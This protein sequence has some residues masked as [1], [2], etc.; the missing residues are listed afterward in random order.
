MENFFDQFDQDKDVISVTTPDPSPPSGNFFDQFDEVQPQERTLLTDEE[1]Q[2]PNM[3]MAMIP[4][5]DRTPVV[6]PQDEV[7]AGG[8]R[9]D[10]FGPEVPPELLQ[11]EAERTWNFSDAG[12]GEGIPPT[13]QRALGGIYNAPREALE[14]PIAARDALSGS[15]DLKVIQEVLD[16]VWPKYK[17]GQ[18]AEGLVGDIIQEG[19]GFA[20]GAGALHKV[21]GA[22]LNALKGTRTGKAARAVAYEGAGVLGMDSETESMTE[23]LRILGM[24]SDGSYSEEV[25]LRKMNIL[26]EGLALAKGVEIGA[27]GIAKGSK[28]VNEY[29]IQPLKTLGDPEKL[30]DTVVRDAIMGTLRKV[31]INDT[32]NDIADDIKKIISAV[33]EGKETRISSGIEGVDDVVFKRDTMSALQEGM[34][35]IDADLVSRARSLRAGVESRGAP[36]ITAAM[37]QPSFEGDRFLTKGREAFG[38]PE[39]AQ[40]SREIIQE[41]ALG[42]TD[43]YFRE[44]AE[45]EK[46][47][48]QSKEGIKSLVEGDPELGKVLTELG[49]DVNIGFNSKVRQNANEL[50]GFIQKA[51]D[52][53]TRE[54][55][56]LYDAIPDR[57]IVN[58]NDYNDQ[59]EMVGE[60]L[61]DSFRKQLGE[62]GTSFKEI[63][64]LVSS[65]DFNNIVS[66]L[67][68]A[69]RWED[70]ARLRTFK[71]AVTDDQLDYFILSGDPEVADAA[72]AAKEYFTETYAPY[73]RN[74]P[75]LRDIQQYSRDF[76]FSPDQNIV[77][78][79]RVLTQTISDPSKA[80][81]T[82]RIG[83]LLDT[84]EGGKNA[85][86]LLDYSLGDVAL[87]AQ[88]MKNAS[89]DG[90]LSPEQVVSLSRRL[91]EFVPIFEQHPGQVDRINTFLSRLKDQTLSTKQLEESLSE[92]TKRA[93]EAKKEILSTKGMENFFDSS[94]NLKT[95]TVESFKSAF[96]SVDTLPD[97]IKRAGP[98][99]LEGIKSQYMDEV[100]DRLFRAEEGSAGEQLT[101]PLSKRDREKLFAAGDIIFK[102]TPEVMDAVRA[103]QRE[104]ARSRAGTNKGKL[105]Y[106]VAS[107]RKGASGVADFLITQIWGPLNRWG[108]R[109]RSA[110]GRAIASTDTQEQMKLILDRV[111]ADPDEFSK[112]AKR[113]EADFRRQGKTSSEAA[114][115]IYRF[116]VTSGAY[117][118][119][120][121]P[122]DE[123]EFVA[124]ITNSSLDDQTDSVLEFE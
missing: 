107:P 90:T 25:A 57:A 123:S 116:F 17:A 46:K 29:L 60:L 8:Y 26:V 110:A 42:D 119:Q 101:K 78:S 30:E 72:R 108:S 59:I 98:E 109:I 21:A 102:D 111:M 70:V 32:P 71:E 16:M 58:L 7:F 115:D 67:K 22:A 89:P 66:N 96:E 92:L 117:G 83:Q 103:V 33:D 19:A 11:E 124:D 51:S 28:I 99:G 13:F 95:N 37:A 44:V 52:T 50:V 40:R 122:E 49:N 87:E 81:Y 23:P 86:K 62:A 39:S 80:E 38:G 18:E 75:A 65:K 120:S 112:I 104:V 114:S 27:K 14:F 77:E 3:R 47:V 48:F 53:M 35:D 1:F 5:D 121:G 93:T 54:K 69:D 6:P 73:W 106:D 9:A 34:E 118:A 85:G 76:K 105:S 79:R 61:P 2:D 55:N 113:V 63:N 94:G 64:R 15:E 31:T 82:Q 10:N 24:T 97:V 84:E 43:A 41:N 74:N 68:K 88:R 36:E 45:A 4:T 56:R 100:Y 91:E 20:T 12:L